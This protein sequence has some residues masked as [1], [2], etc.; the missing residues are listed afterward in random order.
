[1][2]YEK[3]FTPIDLGP[4]HVKNRIYLA[5]VQAGLSSGTY[6]GMTKRYIDYFAERA[7]G[8]A[9]L[10]ITGHVKAER[11]IDPYPR[12]FGLVLNERNQLKDYYELCEAVHAY[13]AK[14]AVE[15]SAG[16]GRIADTIADGFIP[17]APSAGP[18]LF[19][20]KANT[21]ELSK[22]EIQGLVAAYGRA[23]RNAKRA[24]FDLV[25][26]HATAYLIDQFLTPAWNHRSDEYGGSLE[27]RMRF[28]LECIESARAAA[29]DDYPIMATLTMDAGIEGGKTE[30][31]YLAIAQALEAA[32]VVAL[33]V[34]NGS[35]DNMNMFMAPYT[36][37]KPQC[38]EQAAKVK[39]AVGIPVLVEGSLLT[40]DMCE[41]VLEADQA[42]MVGLARPLLADPQWPRKARAG[43][44]DEI[45]PCLRC[46]QCLGR[47][48]KEQS[49]ACSVNPWLSHEGETLLPKS[50]HSGET[51]LVVG[52]GLAGMQAALAA[53]EFGFKV[54]LA[55]ESEELGM[56][57]VAE[58]KPNFIEE[59]KRYRDYLRRRIVQAG[60]DVR[61]NT[62]V[63]FS[64]VQAADPYGVI[65]ATQGAEET[66]LFTQVAQ[67]R[68]LVYAI[69]DTADSRA[70]IRV[71]QQAIA[72]VRA[73]AQAR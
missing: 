22:E 41:N 29:G 13:G 37:P 59:A 52:G 69:D 23:V 7:K 57:M 64:D 1:M 32:G 70:Y 46:M 42:D 19:F 26:V 34:R 27:N 43:R 28:M 61:L 14:I 16:A 51:V 5:P 67:K 40:P 56:R 72:A 53:V 21:R 62:Q 68:L 17:A 24:G 50:P 3:L 58:C 49:I 55:E 10:I 71:N 9:G 33:H 65:F 66:A 20:P 45:T 25:S 44:A 36:A 63:G 48:S 39:A 60:A 38:V 6:G 12:S 15:L 31:D 11:T 4:V 73:I 18:M 47:I 2:S 35:Y 8:G 54:V 30:E